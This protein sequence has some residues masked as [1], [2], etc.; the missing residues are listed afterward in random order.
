MPQYIDLSLPLDGKFRFKIDLQQDRSYAKDGRQSTSYRLS[1]HAYTH[2][3]APRHMVGAD[4]KSIS[5]YPLEYF[6]GEASLIDVPRGKNEPVTGNDLA[7]AGKH[8]KDGDIVF[9][10]TGWLEKMWGKE[11]FYDSPY[12]TDEAAEWLVKLKARIAGYDFL[13]DFVIRNL[14]RKASVP[15][16]G[17]TVHRILLGNEVLNLEYVNNLSSIQVQRFFVYAWPIRLQGLDG[18]PCR[19][20][21]VL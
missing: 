8:C 10:R 12:L 19:P 17:F 18:A 16:E 7:M 13:E 2:L 6:I 4:K 5:D 1:A 21:A 20:V 15:A 11:E 3:D 9:I 14:T